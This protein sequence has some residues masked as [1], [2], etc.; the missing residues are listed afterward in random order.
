[1]YFSDIKPKNKY[2]S[3]DTIKNKDKYTF[4][5]SERGYGKKLFE[6]RKE[7]LFQSCLN[8]SQN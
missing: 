8:Q 5:F 6:R 7:C 4:I 1:M 3:L 2:Y